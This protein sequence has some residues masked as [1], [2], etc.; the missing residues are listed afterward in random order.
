MELDLN[1]DQV[2][3]KLVRSDHQ[4]QYAICTNEMKFV[5][6]LSKSSEKKPLENAKKKA[7][8]TT[9]AVMHYLL[10]FANNAWASVEKEAPLPMHTVHAIV[11]VFP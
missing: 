3:D 6:C 10:K 8:E 4:C 11:M 1:C 9:E 2:S 7:L 5:H